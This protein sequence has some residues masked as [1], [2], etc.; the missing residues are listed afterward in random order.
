MT[1]APRLAGYVE[2]WWQACD[3]LTTLLETIPA[4]RW[5]TPTDLPG[6]DVHAVV[7]HTAH[8][9]AVLAG[10]GPLRPLLE[11][12]IARLGLTGRVRITGWLAGSDVRREIESAYAMFDIDPKVKCV[13]V[14]GEGRIFCAGADLEIQDLPAASTRSLVKPQP[15]TMQ[16]VP[17]VCDYDRVRSVC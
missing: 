1:D 12:E 5:S 4:D 10:D 13:V 8:L 6:W 16:R 9:E 17:A 2:V 14:T 15:L 3:G 7:A 11:T